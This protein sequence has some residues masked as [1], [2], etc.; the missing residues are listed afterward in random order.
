MTGSRRRRRIATM[1]AR[2]K[3]SKIIKNMKETMALKRPM[4]S[5]TCSNSH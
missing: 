1:A 2:K 3:R 5:L 4:G